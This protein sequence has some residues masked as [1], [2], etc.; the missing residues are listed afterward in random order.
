MSINNLLN[1]EVMKNIVNIIN[2]VRG[3]EPR[4]NSLDL[5]LPVRKQFELLCRLNLKATFLLQ[6]DAFTE[7]K[8]ADLFQNNEI[9][10]LGI[11]FEIVQ[12][13]C[14]DAGIEWRGREGFSWDWHAHCDFLIGYTQEQRFKLIDVAMEKF[15]SIFGRYPV[16]VGGWIIDSISLEYLHKKYNIKACVICRDQWGTDG[17]NLWGG[18]YGQGYYP[19]KWNVFSPAQNAENQINV[20]V[21]RML[22]PDPVFQYDA[23]LVRQNDDGTVFYQPSDHQPVRT[24]EPVYQ[25][26]GG[27]PEW[28]DWYFKE[29]FNSKSISFGYA[30][31]GQEN[32]FGW[33]AMKDG[34][35]YQLEKIKKMS[36]ESM[37]AVETLGET[38][39]WYLESFEATPSSA[40]CCDTAYKDMST[41][42][43]WYCSPY[44]R[45]NIMKESQK[46][47]IRD[48]HKFAEDYKDRYYDQ[49]CNCSWFT[50]DTLPVIDGNLWSC[51][52]VRAGI[53]LFFDEEISFDDCVSRTDGSGLIVEANSSGGK[54][55]IILS[56][57]KIRFEATREFKL[58]FIYSPGSIVMNIEEQSIRYE[59]E[60]YG[61]KLNISCG[62]AGLENGVAT[63]QSDMGC[64]EF[65]M[66]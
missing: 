59:H 52:A 17:Y 6:Y 34:L 60:G 13:L 23:G 40:I 31:V 36:D 19:S 64:I 61:Y 37:I 43:Y 63:V 25:N 38:G 62:K 20:P 28:V 56:R 7:R 55:S 8:F 1:G 16:S 11:W 14:Q 66:L 39:Q 9:I 33:E 46:L 53:Y 3:V 4:D 45:A 57:E 30:Q 21:F 58:K 49:P 47:W 2:F 41:S 54:I 5:V 18:Y 32:S 26:A 29:N 48:I 44:Y 12:P 50:Y 42:S 27:N 35:T 15:R 24:L 65:S 22:G 51:G 10:E